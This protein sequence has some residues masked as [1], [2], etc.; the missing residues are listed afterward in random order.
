MTRFARSKG[1][2]ASNERLPE[3]ATSWSE[4]K[5]Q[6]Q[7]IKSNAEDDKKKKEADKVRQENYKKFLEQEEQE[8]NSGEKWADFSNIISITAN[9]YK[10]VTNTVTQAVKRKADGDEQPE[11]KVK[12]VQ[13]NIVQNDKK[14]KLNACE[15]KK[16]RVENAKPTKKVSNISHVQ[17]QE[18]GK[19][20]EVKSIPKEKEVIVGQVEKTGAGVN[21]NEEKVV[22]NKDDNPLDGDN[23]KKGKKKRKRNKKPKQ[24]NEDG[25]EITEAPKAA[26]DIEINKKAKVNNKKKV[27]K[28]SK[29]KKD[30][31]DPYKVQTDDGRS[32]EVGYFDTFMIKKED[33]ARLKELKK[34]MMAKGIPKSEINAALKLE[35]RR[36]EK[37][38]TR[39]RKKVCLNCRKGGHSLADCPKMS[40][41]NKDA[42][43]TGICYK[44]GS[45][46][47]THFEC[48]VVKNPNDF[49]FAT[50]FICKE[51]G[52]I[53]RQ[54]PDNA[55]GLYPKGGACKLCGDVTHL[56]KDC[57]THVAKQE[58]DNFVLD[59]I[60]GGDDLEELDSRWKPHRNFKPKSKKVIRFNK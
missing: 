47:H 20:K 44:C 35:R 28:F 21:D 43:P 55:R 24:V 29:D 15:V 13:K 40:E 53:S 54:C 45:T 22:S 50:C 42:I 60:G 8:K 1:S 5:L 10:K 23:V 30:K 6:M 37:A 26:E 2:K 11:K 58:A 32:I 48:K 9:S 46:E 16:V 19:N 14:E 25:K 18:N 41:S 51:Q 31:Y 56:K 57:P 39:E 52:H 4:M 34:K 38:L 3:E 59:T 27:N 12:K 33:V 17:P 49:K 36:A 7:Q